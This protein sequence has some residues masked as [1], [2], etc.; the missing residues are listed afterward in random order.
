M[1][2]RRVLQALL[3]ASILPAPIVHASP[4]EWPTRVLPDLPWSFSEPTAKSLT[5]FADS[6][7]EYS[8]GIGGSFDSAE[9]QRRFPGRALDVKYEYWAGH[10]RMAEATVPIRTPENPTYLEVLF[11]VHNGVRTTLGDQDRC[12]F[13]GLYLQTVGDVTVYEMHLGS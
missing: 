11:L 8:E 5:S 1:K 2:R 9:L 3:A 13:E 6:L 12:Y 7:R 10:W 4:R